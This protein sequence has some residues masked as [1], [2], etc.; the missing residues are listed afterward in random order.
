MDSCGL[1][2]FKSA[3]TIFTTLASTYLIYLLIIVPSWTALEDYKNNLRHIEKAIEIL[4]DVEA[5]V[6]APDTIEATVD[7]PR[8]KKMTSHVSNLGNIIRDNMKRIFP[9]LFEDISV[10]LFAVEEKLRKVREL[11]PANA[12]LNE[13]MD[14]IATDCVSLRDKFAEWINRGIKLPRLDLLVIR[15]VNYFGTHLWSDRRGS[16]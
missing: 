2:I 10:K 5:T 16:E 7:D 11:P 15:F 4:R 8:L 14:L 3:L 6:D 1:E 13:I 9:D 12:E